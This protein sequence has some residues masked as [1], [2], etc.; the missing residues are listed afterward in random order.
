M[1]GNVKI[2]EVFVKQ[3]SQTVSTPD[4]GV[5]NPYSDQ[6]VGQ[7]AFSLPRPCAR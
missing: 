2:V 3:E 5:A 4:Q 7:V 6:V 1:I